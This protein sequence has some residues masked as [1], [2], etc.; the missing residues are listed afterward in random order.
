MPSVN[1]GVNVNGVGAQI[2]QTVTRSGDGGDCRAVTLNPGISGTLTTQTSS[3]AGV[4]TV[5]SVGSITTS[6]VCDLYWSG[7]CAYN[8]AV[9]ATTSTTITFS[10]ASGSSVP[11]ASTAVVIVPQTTIYMELRSGGLVF[12]CAEQ[13]Y[14]TTAETA[15]S[16]VS[17]EDIS[18]GLVYQTLLAA[19]T[20]AVN[21]IA[22]GMSNPFTGGSGNPVA[23][24]VASNGSLLGNTATLN[25]VWVCSS[26]V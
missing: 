5:A 17:Y 19:N 10:G 2:N 8:C 15:P 12:F 4:V 23:K 6:T 11:I 13:A 3:T 9:T 1:Y 20:P 21:D 7:G 16:H 22:G 14:A 26:T 18:S 25:M 24:A